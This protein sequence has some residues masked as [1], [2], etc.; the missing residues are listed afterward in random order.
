M[1]WT[2]ADIP[3]QSGRTAV[4]TGATSGLGLATATE[5]AR[6]GA[7]VVLTARGGGRGERA[8]AH[9][10]A[11]VPAASAEVAELDLTRL[12]SVRSF[13]AR[14]ADRYPELDLLVNNAGVMATPLER[15]ADGFELQTGTN[16]LGHFA[17]TGR[18]LPLLLA[19]PAAR[20][21]TVSSSGHRPG[22]I[23]LDD[24]NW[25][26]RPYRRWPAYFQSKLA[27]LLFALE[28]Q[29]RLAAAGARAESLAA[30]PGLARTELTRS[31]PGLVGRV[32]SA[33]M[34]A[35]VPLF[36]QSAEQGALPLLRA[37]TDPTVPG[38]SYLGPGGPGEARGLPV[39]VK[40][41]P[42][43]Y[44]EDLAGKLWNLSAELTGVAP[45]V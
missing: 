29:R 18:L 43:A 24:L 15:T 17:L 14:A 2:A 16:H 10:R 42:A 13:A 9:L 19:A 20:V 7:H 35:T 21:V 6:R 12:E 40:A 4:V 36:G 8:L 38:G 44:D 41:A 3:D 11:A 25:Q 39:V 5:L 31:Y 34:R 45:A 30:H 23:V 37:A 27:N 26:R 32:Q 33:L 1:S 28:L 22:R